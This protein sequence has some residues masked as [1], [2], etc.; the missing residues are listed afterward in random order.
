MADKLNPELLDEL[1]VELEIRKD[2][3]DRGEMIVPVHL[4][5]RL[6][7]ALVWSGDEVAQLRED[8]AGTMGALVA[9]SIELEVQGYD[10]NRLAE[11]VAGYQVPA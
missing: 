2:Y 7:E 4:M 8:L 1:A 11:I 6:H 3:P 9:T 10:L 5:R